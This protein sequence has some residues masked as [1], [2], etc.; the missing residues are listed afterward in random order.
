MNGFRAAV[1]FPWRSAVKRLTVSVKGKII[2]RTGVASLA[3][4]SSCGNTPS[5]PPTQKAIHSA[6][7]KRLKTATACAI[8]LAGN[9]LTRNI[10]KATPREAGMSEKR[11]IIG[12]TSKW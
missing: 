10:N 5:T 3:Q 8:R 1:V 4:L 2:P 11:Y 7:G 6:A 12:K 9:I